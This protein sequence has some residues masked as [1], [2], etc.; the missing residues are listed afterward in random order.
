ML[1]FNVN[2]HMTTAIEIMDMVFNIMYLMIHG[3]NFYYDKHF[4]KNNLSLR[5]HN[6][7]ITSLNR[8]I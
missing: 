5:L 8:D 1:S 4:I 7:I 2:L 3:F 6:I